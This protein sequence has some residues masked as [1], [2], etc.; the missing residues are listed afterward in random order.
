M[1]PMTATRPAQTDFGVT[2]RSAA[3]DGDTTVSLGFRPA[4]VFRRRKSRLRVTLQLLQ[5]SVRPSEMP[6]KTS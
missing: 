4:T 1:R 6:V 2:L 3:V 5:T